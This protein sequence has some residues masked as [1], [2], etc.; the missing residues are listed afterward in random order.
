MEG[1]TGDRQG[2]ADRDPRELCPLD[3]SDLTPGPFRYLPAAWAVAF[4][5]AGVVWWSTGTDAF[6]M[7]PVVFAVT[8]V[9]ALW[10]AVRVADSV[11]VFHRAVDEGWLQANCTLGSGMW[12]WSGKAAVLTIAHGRVMIDAENHEEWAAT[13]VELG[14]PPTFWGTGGVTLGTPSGPRRL[15]F[16]SR[17]D[18]ARGFSPIVDRQVHTAVGRALRSNRPPPWQ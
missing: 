8:G 12:Q 13:E 5:I 15:A 17:S 11:G 18:E 7:L 10:R 2:L 14:P 1:G 16:V 3:L 4:P 6:I 9:I